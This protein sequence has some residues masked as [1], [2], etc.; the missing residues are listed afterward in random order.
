VVINMTSDQKTPDQIKP[1]Q[2]VGGAET[3]DVGRGWLIDFARAVDGWLWETDEH[4]RFTYMSSN[5]EELT[6]VPNVWH[7][8]KTREELGAPDI[9][10]EEWQEHLATMRRREPFRKFVYRRRGPDKDA[11]LRSD[12][13]P[14]FDADG[15]FKG[16]RG[17]G[18]FVTPE[19]EAQQEAQRTQQ[20]LSVAIDQMDESFALWDEDDRLVLVNNRFREINEAV[21]HI[22]QPGAKCEDYLRA[23]V[24]AGLVPSAIG[25]ETE[26]LEARM[27]IHLE[28]GQPMEISRQDGRWFLVGEH[29]IPGVGTA[30]IATDITAQ[31]KAEITVLESEQ[32]FRDI[33]D[34]STDWYWE[35]DA[36]HK[37]SFFSDRLEEITGIQIQDVIGKKP[38]EVVSPFFRELPEWQ[39]H[40]QDMADHCPFKA[41]EYPYTKN[42]GTVGWTRVNGNPMFDAAGNFTGYRGAA[43]EVS[44]IHKIAEEMVA[45]RERAEAANKA[46]TEFLSSISHELRTP[47]NS[48]LGFSQL[49]ADDPDAPLNEDQADSLQQILTSGQ[50]LL[51]LINELLDLAQIES[52]RMVIESETISLDGLLENCLVGTS[53]LAENQ[54]I[55]VTSESSEGLLVRADET[56]L[57]QVLLNLLSNAI[58]YNRPDGS[59]TV[60]TEQRSSHCRISVIDTGEG[61]AEEDITKLFEPFNRLGWEN[62]ETEG[63][64]IGLTICK[65]LIEA[66]HGSIG[67]NSIQG[68]GTTFWIDVPLD[69]HKIIRGPYDPEKSAEA[70]LA[71]AS[72]ATDNNSTIL[73]IED[74]KANVVLMQQVIKR[75]EGASLLIAETA[76]AGLTVAAEQHPDVVVMDIN[77]P[78]M[79]GFEALKVMQTRNATRDIPVVALSADAMP[80]QI[81]KGRQVGFVAYLT[82]PLDI[83]RFQM[84]LQDLLQDKPGGTT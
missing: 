24:E 65:R 47:M 67:C 41:F 22:C 46:K 4:L 43:T 62:S 54:G 37:Y 31:K 64:G 83:P 45:S 26:W 53:T 44:E 13:F 60:R 76:E 42:D 75:M 28:P 68:A 84:V 9:P 81:E 79:D 15:T 30:S 3:S 32:R 1:D 82:K 36:E 8:G 27:K 78:G 35:T 70:E 49:M 74:N 61:F 59:V 71:K 55:T 2:P 19:V 38:S 56:R 25:H 58:K 29:H 11:W 6:G 69:R 66:M 23:T 48:I 63:T 39:D 57:R 33:A 40:L 77:L 52:G 18:R 10:E 34:V 7:Y 14:V 73:Y 5:V 51:R 80:H 20:L 17:V 21:M 72:T 50:H 12:G 16:Y